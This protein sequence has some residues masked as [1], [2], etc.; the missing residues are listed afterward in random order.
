MQYSPYEYLLTWPKA[1]NLSGTKIIPVSDTA[2]ALAVVVEY[3]KMSGEENMREYDEKRKEIGFFLDL[4]KEVCKD[5]TKEEE[6]QVEVIR[7]DP[8]ALFEFTY[9]LACY[10]ERLK[11]EEK[12]PGKDASES[13]KMK[14]GGNKAYQEGKD[15]QALTCYTQVRGASSEILKITFTKNSLLSGHNICSS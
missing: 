7:D 2:T 15:L 13:K 11:I 10:K 4:Y 14:E 6:D 9:N 5:M 12:Y 3:R 8:K 1:L